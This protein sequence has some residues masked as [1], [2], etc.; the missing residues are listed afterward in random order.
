MRKTNGGLPR[1]TANPEQQRK[2][3]FLKNTFRRLSGLAAVLGIPLFLFA[4]G[5][6]NAISIGS[7]EFTGVFPRIFTPNSDGFN[8]KAVFH[9]TN[10]EVLPVSG[11]IYDITGS[12]VASLA[13]GSDPETLLTWDGKDSGGRVVPGGIYLF[14]ID[15]QG[16]NITGTVV[17][18]R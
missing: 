4:A 10:P 7:L 14:K 3:V 13:P 12:E 16:E 11:T 8:D 18:A 17:V 2:E 9:F 1:T 6:A 15:F 5:A